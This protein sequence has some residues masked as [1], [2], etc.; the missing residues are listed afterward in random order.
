MKAADKYLRYLIIALGA[1]AEFVIVFYAFRYFSVQYVWIGEILRIVGGV[2]CVYIVNNSRHLSVDIKWI[3][4]IFLFPVPGTLVYLLLGANLVRSSTAKKLYNSDIKSK[5]YFVQD[6]D[7]LAEATE[8]MPDLKADFRYITDYAKYAI[9]RNTGFDY[10]GLGNIGFPVMLEEMEKAEEFIFLEYFIIEEG[11]MWEEMHEILKRKAEEG[12][13]VRVM[14]DDAGSM[15][16]LSTRYARKLE[17]EGI[18]CVRFNKIN[19]FLAAVMNHRDHRKIMVIDG[20]VAFSGG[21]NLADEYINEKVVYGHWKDNCIRIK[22]EAVWSYTVLFLTNWNA[23]RKTDSDYTV[24]KREPLEGELDGY[25]APYGGTPL[26]KQ[27]NIGQSIYINIINSATDYV[28]ICTPYLL[29]DTELENALILA[30]QKGV[31][32]RIIT[33]GIPDKKIVWWIT[34]SFYANLIEAGIKIY[35]Y[36]PGFIH[37]KTFVSD[38]RLATVG[39]F[40][41]DYRSLYLHF[42]NGTYLCDAN[43]VYDIRDDFLETQEVSNRIVKGAIK[44]NIFKKMFIGFVKLFVSQ[45]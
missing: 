13:D 22:G 4:I 44:N 38:D 11:H 15:N 5:E 31:D 25:I 43:A 26:S 18:K 23:L 36:T 39:T 2:I 21:I 29:I 34:R 32:V 10:Y 27:Y 45:M 41:L 12:L 8:K 16:T 33:P 17:K 40:N 37:A 35:E 24:F 6:Q 14:Y 30:S 42:E 20:K 19:P 28:Y 7:V 3:M 1:I 9:Y